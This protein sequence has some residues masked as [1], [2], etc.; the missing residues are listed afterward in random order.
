MRELVN[1]YAPLLNRW[2]HG[3]LPSGA[4]GLVETQDLVQVALVRVL[5]RIDEFDSRHPG[6]FLAY[7]RRTLLN[8]IRNEIRNASRRPQ[9]GELPIDHH[10]EQPSALQHAIGREAMDAYEQALTSL[11]EDQQAAVIMRV[12]LGCAYKEI[13]ETL[14]CPSA[15]AARMLVTRALD[16]L[17]GEMQTE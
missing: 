8:Q 3:R 17:A 4:R 1:T 16:R 10:D 14:G 9:G 2:A 12:E 11:K 6:A 7:V 13:A 15:N 5:K